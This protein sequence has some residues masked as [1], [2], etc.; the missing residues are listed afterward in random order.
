M[1]EV[2]LSYLRFDNVAGVTLDCVGDLRVYDA[3]GPKLIGPI[4]RSHVPSLGVVEGANQLGK[5]LLDSDA[6]AIFWLDCDMGFA[7]NT[8]E[9]LYLA[10]DSE[11]RHAVSALT[12]KYQQYA[13]DGHGGYLCEPRPVIMDW[14]EALD[15]TQ[16]FMCRRVYPE[17]TLVQCQATGM[18]CV[19]I[20]RQVYEGIF[21]KF[22]PVWHTPMPAPPECPQEFLGPDVSFWCRAAMC[23]F[24]LFVHT[25]VPTTHQKTTWVSHNSYEQIVGDGWRQDTPPEDVYVEAVDTDHGWRR[26]QVVAEPLNRAQRRAAEKARR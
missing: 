12:F 7:P 16:G 2:A 19:V 4:H 10:L 3:Y 24:N 17:N 8:L 13:M 15:G 18:A 1:H 5:A 11:K 26:E 25:G 21:E 23:G 9:R 20:Q 6:K 14:G 22:G